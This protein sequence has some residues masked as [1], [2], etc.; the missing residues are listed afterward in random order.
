LL[1]LLPFFLRPDHYK[2][3]DDENENQ[4]HKKRADAPAGHLRC[5]GLSLS[6]NRLEHEWEIEERTLNAKAPAAMLL[7]RRSYYDTVD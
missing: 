5:R 3:H 6:K 1:L 4:R 7:S 2:I